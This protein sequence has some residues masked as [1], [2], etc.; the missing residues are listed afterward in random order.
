MHAIPGGTVYKTWNMSA[1][2]LKG[3]C[4]KIIFLFYEKV[5]NNKKLIFLK[6]PYYR[7]K[8]FRIG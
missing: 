1:M 2:V 5:L 6:K 3:M 7:W 8:M 4:L